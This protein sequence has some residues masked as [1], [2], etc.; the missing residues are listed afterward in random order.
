MDYRGFL[1]LYCMK[2]IQLNEILTFKSIRKSHSDYRYGGWYLIENIVNGK[3][4]IGKSIDYMVR[5]RQHL[6]VKNPKTL[7][8]T[9]I[10]IHG[11][12]SFRFYVLMHYQEVGV[13]FFNRKIEH[14]IEND[15]IIN[16]NTKHPYGYNMRFYE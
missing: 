1:I 11:V 2:E 8:D 4:Y 3:R 10:S 13:N 6:F 14:K 7:I 5:L 9:E 12:D 16:M 15:L